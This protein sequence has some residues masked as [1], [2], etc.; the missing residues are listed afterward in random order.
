MGR[1]VVSGFSE[2][3]RFSGFLEVVLHRLLRRW[4]RL[5]EAVEKSLPQSS[6]FRSNRGGKNLPGLSVIFSCSKD[7]TKVTCRKLSGTR[8]NVKTKN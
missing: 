2:E 7:E 3:D 5:F 4:R 1:A 8:S 6:H